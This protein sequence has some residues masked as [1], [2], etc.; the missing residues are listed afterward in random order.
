MEHSRP[1]F[2]LW[3]VIGLDLRVRLKGNI[4]DCAMTQSGKKIQIQF[5]I[6]DEAAFALSK[7]LIN[8]IAALL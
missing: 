8:Q 2:G 5:S 4:R 1:E 3:A 6:P 7:Q